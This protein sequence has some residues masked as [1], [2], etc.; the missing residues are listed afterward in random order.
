MLASPLLPI[1]PPFSTQLVSDD[2]LQYRPS[3]D[4]EAFNSLLP[5]PIEFVEGSSSG[6]LAVPLGKYEP[7]NASP[8]AVKPNVSVSLRYII[9]PLKLFLQ[10]PELPPPSTP[11][12]SLKSPSAPSNPKSAS[13]YHGGIESSW[14]VSFTRGN[15]L[16]NSGNTCFLNSAVQCLLHTPP[17]LRMLGSHKQGTCTLLHSQSPSVQK[18]ILF[19]RSRRQGFLHDL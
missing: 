18:L 16:Y 9:S 17:L 12:K 15:G 2:S 7:I 10:R 8:K 14:P 11:V 13:L 1:Q 19:I 5:P 6:A 3:R 4:K